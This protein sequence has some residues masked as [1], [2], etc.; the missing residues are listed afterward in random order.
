MSARG[1]STRAKWESV[2]KTLSAQIAAYQTDRETALLQQACMLG[3]RRV[4]AIRPITKAPPRDT[5]EFAPPID[6]G[7]GQ[8]LL[9][10]TVWQATLGKFGM[11]A[12][13]AVPLRDTLP[14]EALDKTCFA[15]QT[16]PLQ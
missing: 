5:R 1:A 15:E 12:Q 7:C 2:R 3:Q 4:V 13:R 11:N 6:I 9:D 14:H 16:L 10:E 8:A